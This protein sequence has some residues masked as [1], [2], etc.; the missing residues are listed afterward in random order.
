MLWSPEEDEEDACR[1]PHRKMNVLDGLEVF[2]PEEAQVKSIAIWTL[3][4]SLVRA[5]GLPTTDPNGTDVIADSPRG[6]WICPVVLRSKGHGSTQRN[7]SSLLTAEFQLA[8]SPMKIAFVSSSVE[9]YN[10]LRDNAS[11]R[12]ATRPPH[13]ALL[14]PEVALDSCEDFIIIYNEQLYLAMRNV[15]P[16]QQLTRRAQQPVA[17]SASPAERQEKV[18]DSEP[19][20]QHIT[21]E[22][23]CGDKAE[24]FID[25][26]ADL[27]PPAGDEVQEDWNADPND[28]QQ[29]TMS[30]TVDS[31]F[32]STLRDD[33]DFNELE[34][35]EKI[36]QIKA[37]LKQT[38]AALNSLHTTK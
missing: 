21:C 26:E 19:V 7:A 32:C 30:L 20:E 12:V 11:G 22:D 28:N 10:V 2:I 31:D 34:Q 36:A 29:W 4:S 9:A 37:K 18:N 1:H 3:P 8:Q 35:R 14:S 38:E 13:T 5:I 27:F 23:P 16:S 33:F 6:I 24:Q 25:K 15:K 17:R